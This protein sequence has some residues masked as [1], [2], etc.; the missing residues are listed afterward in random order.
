MSASGDKLDK[1]RLAI[2]EHLHRK[3]RRSE[4]PSRAQE[5]DSYDELA[6]LGLPP[7]ED[8]E[9]P[10]FGA[11]WFDTARHALG[12]WW[13]HHPAHLALELATPAISSYARRK[14]AQFLG[15]AAAT[16]AVILIARPW[17]LVSATGLI[18]LVLKSSQLSNL[19][20]SAM[21]AADFQKDHGK[22]PPR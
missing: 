9:A 18:A 8:G 19:V 22:P 15:I 14:P 7:G 3:E 17:K 5:P 16:G 20:M 12:V 13:R 4:R 11:N 21:S 1:S 2:I 10:A 6:A